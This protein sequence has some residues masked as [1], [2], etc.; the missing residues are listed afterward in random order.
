MTGHQASGFKMRRFLIDTD[1]ASDDA[2]ALLMAFAAP[3]IRVEALTI[4]AGNCSATQAAQNALYTAEVA[5][6][7]VPVFVGA[8]RPLLRPMKHAAEVHGHDGLGD[9][10]LPLG[11]RAVTAGRGVDAIVDTILAH[12]GEIELVALGPLTNIAIALARAPEIAEKVKRCV[13]MGG[14]ADG[15]GNVTPAA[16]FNIHVDPEAAAMVFASGMPVTMVGWDVSRKAAGFVPEEL[17]ALRAIGTARAEFAV[18][19]LAALRRFMIAIAGHDAIDLPDPIAMAVALDPA[20]ATDVRHLP[21]IVDT[22]QGPSAGATLID[23]YR[24]SG[25]P[26]TVDVVF[27]ADRGRF[28]DLLRRALA[29]G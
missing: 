20:V 28:L 1:T 13:V 21:V 24:L 23:H 29:A 12:P 8:A 14:A 27:A 22:S 6:I 2:I 3:D 15:V 5:G 25:Q 17:A 19:I 26:A 11:G 9:I 7:K 16:E 4:V 18:D 10:G